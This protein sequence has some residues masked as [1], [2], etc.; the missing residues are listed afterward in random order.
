MYNQARLGARKMYP[1][2]TRVQ[3][4]LSVYHAVYPPRVDADSYFAVL[5]YTNLSARRFKLFL[6]FSLYYF[7]RVNG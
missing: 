5:S 7:N 2:R 1:S 3:T 4:H 6:L